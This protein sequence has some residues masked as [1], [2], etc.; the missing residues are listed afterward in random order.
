MNVNEIL[1]AAG[2]TRIK[3]GAKINA[4]AKMLQN[5]KRVKKIIFGILLHRVV[6]MVDMQ[7]VLLTIQ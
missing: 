2:V 7:E 5:I 6:K 3:A 1:I 4:T